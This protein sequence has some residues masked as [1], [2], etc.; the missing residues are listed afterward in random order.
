MVLGDAFFW[1]QNQLG[2]SDFELLCLPSTG[3]VEEDVASP[4]GALYVQ[5]LMCRHRGLQCHAY[6]FL[7]CQRLP[8]WRQTALELFVPPPGLPAQALRPFACVWL[9]KFVQKTFLGTDR[10]GR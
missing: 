5:P 2:D 10:L 7:W 9:P 4:F 3:Q 8:W 6:V 1:N